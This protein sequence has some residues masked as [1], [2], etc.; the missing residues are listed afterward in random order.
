[1]NRCWGCHKNWYFSI[2][3]NTKYTPMPSFLTLLFYFSH[4]C[5]DSCWNW[6]GQCAHVST[7]QSAP[8]P[9]NGLS[10]KNEKYLTD[11]QIC[12]LCNFNI[13]TLNYTLKYTIPGQLHGRRARCNGNAHSLTPDSTVP[14]TLTVCGTDCLSLY[15]Q[16][17]S[18]ITFVPHILTFHH[19]GLIY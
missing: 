4:G 19:V 6:R 7:E 1:M 8:L 15:C 14:H 9:K 10:L 11:L 2:D 5:V 12:F 17:I 16:Y 18:L 13:F 3:A